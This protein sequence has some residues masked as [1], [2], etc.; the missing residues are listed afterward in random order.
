MWQFYRKIDTNKAFEVFIKHNAC[1]I[2]ADIKHISCIKREM[3][4]VGNH[5]M[6]IEKCRTGNHAII[7]EICQIMSKVKSCLLFV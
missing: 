5:N 3:L 4:A 7:C 6:A 2:F 1:F